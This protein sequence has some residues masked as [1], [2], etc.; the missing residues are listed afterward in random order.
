NAF[1]IENQQRLAEAV[2]ERAA[3]QQQ[4]LAVQQRAR[5][6]MEGLN[7]QLQAAVQD[8]ALLFNISRR[9]AGTRDRSALLNDALPLLV[10]MLPQVSAGMLALRHGADR[11]LEIVSIVECNDP[12]A[13]IAERKEQGLMLAEYTARTGNPSWMID[14]EV[15]PL[16]E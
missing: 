2:S 16:E 12:A 6:E 10:D 9:M 5:V 3:A 7:Q 1:E 14:H 4:A 11:P 13:P 15:E 8:L